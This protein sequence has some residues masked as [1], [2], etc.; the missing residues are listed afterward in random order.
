MTAHALPFWCPRFGPAR[1]EPQAAVLEQGY[2]ASE[3]ASFLGCHASN[4]S[5]ALQKRGSNFEQESQWVTPVPSDRK[6]R[7][8]SLPPSNPARGTTAQ[9]HQA[10]EPRPLT[11]RY[12]NNGEFIFTLSDG[13]LLCQPSSA[14]LRAGEFVLA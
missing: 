10:T 9:N 13:K 7:R 1:L 5:R 3:V 4:V 8:E 14:T 2:Q 12:L 11:C 6:R